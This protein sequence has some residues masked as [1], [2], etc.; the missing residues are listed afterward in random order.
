M[1]NVLEIA[2]LDLFENALVRQMA[3]PIDLKLQRRYSQGAAQC[4]ANEKLLTRRIAL[5]ILFPQIEMP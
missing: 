3:V 1:A 4:S 2:A 5:G